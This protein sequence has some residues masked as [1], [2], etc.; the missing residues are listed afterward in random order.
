MKCNLS[1]LQKEKCKCVVFVLGEKCKTL[2]TGLRLQ[3]LD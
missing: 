1:K 3:L 2:F